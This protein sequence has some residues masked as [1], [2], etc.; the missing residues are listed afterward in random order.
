MKALIGKGILRE[1]QK[2]RQERFG[3]RMELIGGSRIASSNRIL[4]G[5]QVFLRQSG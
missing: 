1:K 5:A 2:L 3:D 4:K